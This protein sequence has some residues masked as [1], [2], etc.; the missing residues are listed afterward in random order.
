MY[1][2]LAEYNKTARTPFEIRIGINCGPVVA[3]VI[4]KS[5]F[6]YD[7]WGDTVNVASRMEALC[8]KGEILVTE[9]VKN[10]CKGGN[11]KFEPAQEI[12]VKGK[13]LMTTYVI[14][15]I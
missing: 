10:A 5:K 13:G 9:C 14:K 8:P 4:G 3:G 11:V 1:D 7:L 2:E 15:Q 12:E 6:I